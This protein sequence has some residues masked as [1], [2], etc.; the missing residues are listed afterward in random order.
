[1]IWLLLPVGALILLI[2][3]KTHVVSYVCGHIFN[4]LL[5]HH[6]AATLRVLM[7]LTWLLILVFVIG[8]VIAAYFAFS[9]FNSL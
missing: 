3:L 1:M 7:I 5:D 8:S 4:H 9:F 6:E 2:L